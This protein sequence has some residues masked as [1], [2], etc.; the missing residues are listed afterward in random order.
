MSAQERYD[1]YAQMAQKIIT[2]QPAATPGEQAISLAAP[3]NQI[4]EK[5]TILVGVLFGV[6]VV[7]LTFIKVIP[8]ILFIPLIFFIVMLIKF[9]SIRRYLVVATDQRVLFIGLSKVNNKKITSIESFPYSSVRLGDVQQRGKRKIVTI[10]TS[11]GRYVF[12]FFPTILDLNLDPVLAC[13]QQ[14]QAKTPAAVAP[15]EVPTNPQA[16]GNQ[17]QN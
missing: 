17:N 6:A 16:N 12:Q 10:A 2:Q 5:N 1:N 4:K 8:G 11:A 3:Q 14:Q 13:I 15:T 9:Y 7:V